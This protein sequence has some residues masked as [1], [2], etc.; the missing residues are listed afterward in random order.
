MKRTK[1]HIIKWT[2]A[3][4]I[5]AVYGDY[6]EACRVVEEKNKKRNLIYLLSG[7]RWVVQTFDVK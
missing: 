1:V 4:R 2:G 7:D 5:N 6:D 3:S